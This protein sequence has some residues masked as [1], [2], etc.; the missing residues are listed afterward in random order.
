[1]TYAFLLILQQ[2]NQKKWSLN[3][4][5][6]VRKWL[7]QLFQIVLCPYCKQYHLIK[8]RAFFDTS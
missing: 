8:Q 2:K 1:M 4:F 7:N 6:A 3:T 5:P